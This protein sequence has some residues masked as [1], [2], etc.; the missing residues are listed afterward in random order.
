MVAFWL[1]Q[2]D[3]PGGGST[4]VKPGDGKAGRTGPKTD[5]VFFLAG[6]WI[7]LDSV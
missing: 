2:L 6:R 5:G 4:L 1:E 7:H 3:A